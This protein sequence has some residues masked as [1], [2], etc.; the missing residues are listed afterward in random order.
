[1]LKFTYEQVKLFGVIVVI[2]GIIYYILVNK[3]GVNKRNNKYK[4]CV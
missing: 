3:K 4:K 2:F 1:M